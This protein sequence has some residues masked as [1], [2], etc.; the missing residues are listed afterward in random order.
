M[1]LESVKVQKAFLTDSKEMDQYIQDHHYLNSSQV[2]FGTG[3][4]S[5]TINFIPRNLDKNNGSQH[6][7]KQY[8][9]EDLILS[10]QA[11]V[12]YNTNEHS[13][14]VIAESLMSLHGTAEWNEKEIQ[15]FLNQGAT[16][17]MTPVLKKITFLM[18]ALFDSSEIVGIIP[19]FLELA[20]NKLKT[21]E[22]KK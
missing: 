3:Q 20:A 10:T 15:S 22:Q 4:T 16:R 6:S 19:D 21:P 8:K 12:L 9:S 18:Y 14:L 11:Q 7:D 2:H 17:I 5:M 1:H 13:A